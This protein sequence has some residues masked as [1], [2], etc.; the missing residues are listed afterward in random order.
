MYPF[1]WI[2]QQWVSVPSVR[3]SGSSQKGCESFRCASLVSVFV[4]FLQGLQKWAAPRNKRCVSFRPFNFNI[5]FIRRTLAQSAL[6]TQ[7][8]F[9]EVCP[10][11]FLFLA[12]PFFSSCAQFCQCVSSSTLLR[13]VLFGVHSYEVLLCVSLRRKTYCSRQKTDFFPLSQVRNARNCQLGRREGFCSCAMECVVAESVAE[14]CCFLG[15]FLLSF[16]FFVQLETRRCV[17]TWQLIEWFHMCTVIRKV[18]TVNSQRNEG[19]IKAKYKFG[20]FDRLPR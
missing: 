19:T 17:A 16:V 14:T 10:L 9:H 20:S 7:T 18:Y 3:E 12:F 5:L 11:S 4:A 6:F 2:L 13:H 1:F 15:F 8:V